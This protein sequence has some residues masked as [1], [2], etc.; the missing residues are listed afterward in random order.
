MKARHS[1]TAAL[2]LCVLTAMLSTPASA[3]SPPGSTS[4]L[5]WL[6]LRQGVQAYTDDDREGT[7]TLT[8]CLSLYLYKKWF[9]KPG[10]VVP[11]CSK[12]SRGVPVT[13][14]S[15]DI[16]TPEDTVLSGL[17]FVFI[18]ADDSSWSGWTNSVWLQPRIPANTNVVVS[19]GGWKWFFPGKTSAAGHMVLSDGTTLQILAQDPKSDGPDLYAQ[20]IGNSSDAGKKGWLHRLGLNVQ[21]D[22]PL[23]FRPRNGAKSQR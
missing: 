3:G 11:E 6:E 15:N 5:P 17:Y 23:V 18:R 10:A 19:R 14:A 13:I 2:A 12:K 8:V 1:T 21:G 9:A 4:P 7:S 16:V 22:G 20:I